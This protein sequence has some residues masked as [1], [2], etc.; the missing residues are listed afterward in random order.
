[1]IVH[2]TADKVPNFFHLAADGLTAYFQHNRYKSTDEK[3]TNLSRLN[4]SKREY[5]YLNRKPQKARK[6]LVNH[7]N[8]VTKLEKIEIS[9]EGSLDFFCRKTEKP[10][11]KTEKM[12]V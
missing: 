11:D 4:P 8:N 3:P 9:K 10:L 1:M 12:C 2:K 7:A 6:N 5:Y